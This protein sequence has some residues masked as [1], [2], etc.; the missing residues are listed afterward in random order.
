MAPGGH[1]RPCRDLQYNPLNDVNL[2]APRTA[3]PPKKD[4]KD[5]AALIAAV[6]EV[7]TGIGA[8][9]ATGAIQAA[10]VQATAFS[11]LTPP[12]LPPSDDLVSRQ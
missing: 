2:D 7:L 5:D 3:R 8:P 9:V 10:P 4:K 11:L 6:R 12:P 1:E